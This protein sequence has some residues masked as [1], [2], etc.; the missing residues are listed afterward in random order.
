M[1]FRS[2]WS[3]RKLSKLFAVTTTQVLCPVMLVLLVAGCSSTPSFPSISPEERF[4]ELQFQHAR[5]LDSAV[6]N[7]V[8]NGDRAASAS[9]GRSRPSGR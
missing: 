6:A 4:V 7:G 9:V 3:S 8:G 2:S 5:A 1:P